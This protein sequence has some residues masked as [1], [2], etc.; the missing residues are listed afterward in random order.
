MNQ[1]KVFGQIARGTL[2]L[3]DCSEG[4]V[5]FCAIRRSFLRHRFNK[6]DVVYTIRQMARKGSIVQVNKVLEE[7]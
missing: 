5:T 1:P 4:P 7:K 2:N 3:I 6:E